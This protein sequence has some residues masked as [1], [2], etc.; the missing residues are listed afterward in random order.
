[1]AGKTSKNKLALILP[2]LPALILSLPSQQFAE[3][4]TTGN[5]SAQSSV[6][7]EVNGGDVYTKI[8]LE[9]NGEKKVLETNEPGTHSLEVKS[10]A[11][12]NT[13]ASSS[14][15]TEESTEEAKIKKETKSS[16]GNIVQKIFKSISNFFQKILSIFS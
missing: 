15:S 6:R 3:T 2:I 13:E 9:A 7:N 11:N 14:V 1:M 12:S 8:E 5:A 4:I 16:A 10:D